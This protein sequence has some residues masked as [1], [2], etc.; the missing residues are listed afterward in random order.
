MR[1]IAFA[2]TAALLAGCASNPLFYRLGA[3]YYPV[4][5]IGNQ[6]EY[7]V[8][9]GGTV[10]T[11]VVDQAVVGERSCYRLQTGAHYS[12]WINDEG[13][14]E[15]Y[16]DHRVVFNGY[17]VPVYQ[18]WVPYLEWPLAV[19]AGRTDSAATFS[20]AQGVTIS[21]TWRRETV[22][23]AISSFG[24]W[25]ECYLLEQEETFVDWIQ[26]GGFEPETLTVSRQLWLAPDV[27]LVRKVTADSTLTLTS[28]KPGA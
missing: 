21:H 20:T 24:Q 6:W 1:G 27:G 13:V 10:I 22:V 28:F 18:A 15:H 7:D 25:E 19:G 5:V 9:G 26:T 23:A 8:D 4:T 2:C 3:D 12:C 14:L 17:E 16:E 11:T